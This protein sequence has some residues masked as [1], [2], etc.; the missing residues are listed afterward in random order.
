MLTVIG[1]LLIAPM[2]FLCF[3][4]AVAVARATERPELLVTGGLP[5]DRARMVKVGFVPFLRRLRLDDPAAFSA[6]LFIVP[7]SALSPSSS[8]VVAQRFPITNEESLPD[9]NQL[10]ASSD[11]CDRV[12]RLMVRVPCRRT[13][14]DSG[15]HCGVSLAYGGHI[16]SLSLMQPL[17]T[18]RMNSREA[19]TQ[20]GAKP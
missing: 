19:A 13:S 5:T 3:L 9:R 14:A 1:A 20:S 18:L 11:R 6:H 10:P 7:R 12:P 8:P 15:N 2:R 16:H 4:C 17:P